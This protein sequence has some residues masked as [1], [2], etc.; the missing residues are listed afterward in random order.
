M[1]KKLTILLSTLLLMAS[2]SFSQTM[3]FK[4]F[5]VSPAAAAKSSTDIFDVEYNGLT[6]VGV[7]TKMYLEAKLV[8]AKLNNPQFSLT[9]KPSGSNAT[10]GA[11]QTIDTSSVVIVFTPDVTG[12]YVVK[13]VDGTYSATLTISAGLYLGVRGKG[14]DGLHLAC[15]DCHNGTDSYYPWR[16]N[17]IDKWQQTGHA[18]MFQRGLDGEVSSHYS[19]SCIKCHTTGYD[20]EAANDGFDDFPFVFPT[21]LQ[22]GT[23]DAMVQQYPDAMLRAN[24]QC[25]SCHGPGSEHYGY[26]ENSRMVAS[27]DVAVCAYCHDDGNHHVYPEQW[28]LSKHATGETFESE[29]GNAACAQCHNGLG[30]VQYSRGE[31]INPYETDPITCAVCH[32]PHDAT[33]QHQLRKVD[34]TLADGTVINDGGLGKL[35][36]NCHKSRRVANSSYTTK[37]A[38]HYGPHHGPQA[39]VLAGKNVVVFNGATLQS[40]RHL[41]ATVPGGDANA[42]VNCHMAPGAPDSTGHSM[43]SGGHTFS[44]TTPDGQDNMNACAQCHGNTFGPSFEDVNFYYGGTADLDGNGVAEGLQNEVKGLVAKIRAL[45]PTPNSSDDP[46]AS[47]TTSQLQAFYNVKV[48]EEDKSWGIHNPKFI[49][50]MLINTYVALGGTP[51]V[52]ENTDLPTQYSIYQNYPNPFNPSTNIKFDLPTT[53]HVKLTIYD[54]IGREVGVLVNGEL[55]AGTHTFTWNAGSLASG[56]YF[57]KIEA[58]NFVKVNKMLLLK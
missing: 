2:T 31:T 38:A 29:G 45:L 24:I 17:L 53:S 28:A 3:E 8:G 30:F 55:N 36:M 4:T 50:S 41:T 19:E 43:I 54:S 13:V 6:N 15:V 1:L 22:P 25:E 47:W 56:V 52:R 20:K 49:V 48:V 9:S 39:D 14:R 16:S 46:D 12:T 34:V 40:S 10:F 27:L 23:Y 7:G 32:N 44:M 58:G 21:T 11:T 37:P 33:N 26:I 57:Y 35:C 42:C 5:G 18:T 51:V